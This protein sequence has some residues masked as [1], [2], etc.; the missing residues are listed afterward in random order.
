MATEGQVNAAFEPDVPETRQTTVTFT[1]LS[2]K[3]LSAKP[4][5]PLKKKSSLLSLWSNDSRDEKL[6]SLKQELEMDEHKLPLPTLFA[7][8]NTDPIM[9]YIHVHNILR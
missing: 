6:K 8:L 9:V 3:A 2:A 5:T 7:R 4:F 1:G